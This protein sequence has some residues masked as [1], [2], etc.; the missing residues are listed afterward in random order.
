LS[1]WMAKTAT[2]AASLTWG[3]NT[4]TPSGCACG[5]SDGSACTASLFSVYQCKAVFS[6]V[7]TVPVR[8]WVSGTEAVAKTSV[9][10]YLVPGDSGVAAG[11]TRFWGAQLEAGVTTPGPYCPTTTGTCTTP[12]TVATVPLPVLGYANQSFGFAQGFI[13]NIS[14]NPTPAIAVTPG[15][16]DPDGGTAAVRL[17]FSGNTDSSSEIALYNRSTWSLLSTGT[18]TWSFWA[19]NNS[20]TPL[21]LPLGTFNGSVYNYN[22]CTLSSGWTLCSVTGNHT[23]T[24]TN[25]A[26]G[27]YNLSPYDSVGNTGRLL[28]ATG[29]DITVYGSQMTQTSTVQ[30]YVPTT[31][32]IAYGGNKWCV[33]VTATPGMGSTWATLKDAATTIGNYSGVLA[34]SFLVTQISS[35]MPLRF[36]LYD[37]N[38]TLLSV[39]ASPGWTD[40]A[41][42]RVVIMNFSGSPSMYYDGVAVG[43]LSGAGTGLWSATRPLNLGG[44]GTGVNEFNGA[45]SN[46]KIVNNPKSWRECQ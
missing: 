26:L 11:T 17:Q 1:A 35:A 45:L 20:A 46:L 21:V 44:R 41:P 25:L 16:T 10:T 14:G 23:G 8:G 33:G 42:H 6:A 28:P 36:D 13:T 15:Q 9:E 2:G 40:R 18:H 27:W 30:P 32:A 37:A 3:N 38:A 4:T 39:S 29:A 12:A 31:S 19:K 43:A 5:T 7:G 34:N 24:S 22:T